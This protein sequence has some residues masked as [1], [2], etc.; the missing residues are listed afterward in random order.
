MAENLLYVRDRDEWRTWLERRIPRGVI[1]A[2]FVVTKAL[3]KEENEDDG[4]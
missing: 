3:E 4:Y 2:T 1:Q